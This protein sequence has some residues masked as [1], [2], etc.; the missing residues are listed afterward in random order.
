MYI[1]VCVSV[2]LSVCLSRVNPGLG[3]TIHCA[4]SCVG[5]IQGGGINEIFRADY[6]ID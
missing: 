1:Y 5:N 6:R 2:C 3:W 4:I